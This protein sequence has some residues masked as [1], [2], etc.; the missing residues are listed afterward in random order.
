MEAVSGNEKKIR[1]NA[2]I[3]GDQIKSHIES[4]AFN[5]HQE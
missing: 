3:I 5:V 2:L 4:E 1:P